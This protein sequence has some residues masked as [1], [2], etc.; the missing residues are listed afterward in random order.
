[1]AEVRRTVSLPA[2]ADEVWSLVGDYNGLPQWLPGIEKSEL[3][4]DGAIR[5][6]TLAEGAGEVVEVLEEHDP[7]GRTY[8]YRIIESG[9]PIKDYV[10]TMTVHEQGG[11]SELEWSATFESVG[12]SDEEASAIIEGIYDAGIGGLKERFRG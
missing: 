2:H 10:S 9:L 8:T 6:L 3:E 1:M 11:S 4:Q 5:R 7:G 12:V